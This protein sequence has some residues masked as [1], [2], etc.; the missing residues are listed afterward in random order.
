MIFPQIV[1]GNIGGFT[2]T[3]ELFAQSSFNGPCPLAFSFGTG[4]GASLSLP[5]SLDD[6]SQPNSSFVFVDGVPVTGPHFIDLPP[7]G[8]RKMTV[9]VPQGTEPF[10]GGAFVDFIQGKCFNGVN[11]SGTYSIADQNLR[12]FEAF[13]YVPNRGSLVNQCVRNYVNRNF[14]RAKGSRTLPAAAFLSRNP[15]TGVQACHYLRNESNALLHSG[16]TPFNGGHTAMTLDQ[17]APNLPDFTGFWDICFQGPPTTGQKFPDRIGLLAL[18]IDGDDT[19]QFRTSASETFNM[20]C[21]P[22]PNTQCLNDGRFKVEV[23]WRSFT[24]SGLG[25][26]VATNTDT[27]GLFYFVDP[28][29]WELLV[30]VLDGCKTMSLFNNYWVFYA[31]TTD[32]EFNLT[33]TDTQT[34]DI[35]SASNPLGQAAEA[36]TDTSAFATCP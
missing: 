7:K 11:L 14:D 35:W 31:N 28:E 25:N 15:L 9:T 1:A 18:G 24:A 33:V 10:V 20:A 6:N 26:T 27:T 36:I 12:K 30:N 13:S 8:S 34:N 19:T 17:V 29:N 4:G 23:D 16:C 2:Y 22:G 32:V 5:I 21:M 3:T